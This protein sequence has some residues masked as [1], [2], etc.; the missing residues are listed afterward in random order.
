MNFFIDYKIHLYGKNHRNILY[1]LGSRVRRH[2]KLYFPNY[3]KILFFLNK[4]N[5]KSEEVTDKK[6]T[7]KIFRSLLFDFTY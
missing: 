1:V 5:R 2:K 3:Q 7:K 4:L 6:E